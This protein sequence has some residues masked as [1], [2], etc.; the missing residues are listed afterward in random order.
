MFEVASRQIFEFGEFRL[1][2]T[3]RLLTK[4]GETV[5]LTHKAFETLA[6]LV[7][8][9]G[10]VVTKEELL[11][12][13]WPDTFVEEGSLARNISVLRKALG[14][15]PGEHQFIQTIPKQGYRF[16]APVRESIEPVALPS[17]E[18]NKENGH[19]VHVTDATAVHLTDEP[20][21]LQ[22][23][24]MPWAIAAGIVGAVLLTAAAFLLSTKF[25]NATR[26]EFPE[27]NSAG[28]ASFNVTRFTATGKALDAAISR[29]GKYVVFVQLDGAKQS[30][31]VKQVAS[32][33]VVRIV[34]PA[35]VFYQGLAF[36]ADGGYVFY[37]VWDK[38]HVGEIYKIPVLG[39]PATRVV[40]DVMPTLAVSPDNSEIVFV[41]SVSATGESLLMAAK[42]DGSGERV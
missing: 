4:N 9:R 25:S 2:A 36:T 13:I 7:E 20:N 23:H 19:G 6:L 17:A 5:P 42:T 10:R 3:R 37:N 40:N 14:E 21:S 39:G 30:L 29:D 41:R 8:H 22:R 28:P 12:E 16:V 35:D 24:P 33:S 31:W 38:Q 1:D 11:S 27:T 32:G 26:Q 15:Q 18:P 34:E